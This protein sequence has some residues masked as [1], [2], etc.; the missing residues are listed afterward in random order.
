MEFTLQQVFDKCDAFGDV[1]TKIIAVP[2]ELFFRKS[3]TDAL[4][5]YDRVGFGKGA[6]IYTKEKL[7]A[8]PS[9][10]PTT[11]TISHN[12]MRQYL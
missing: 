9:S 11:W 4:E 8:S 6:L 1:P 7:E 12:R 10:N 3:F 2:F 5:T